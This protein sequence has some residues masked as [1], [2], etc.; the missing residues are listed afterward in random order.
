MRTLAHFT[1]AAALIGFGLAGLGTGCGGST[2]IRSSAAYAICDGPGQCVA[3][4]PGCC[5]GCGAPTLAE[6]TGVNSDKQDA[7][8]AATC[9]DPHPVCPACPTAPEPNLVAYCANGSCQAHDVRVDDVSACTKDD[10]CMLRAASCCEPCGPSSFELIALAKTH[11]SDY[12]AKVCRPDAACSKCLPVYPAGLTASCA[13]DGHCRVT[14]KGNVCPESQPSDGAPCTTAVTCEY[15]EDIRPGCRT[16]ATCSNA[17]WQV[18]VSGCPPLPQA[19][20]N[21][22]PSTESSDPCSPEGLACD[23]GGDTTCVCS[24]CLGGPCSPNPRWVCSGPPTTEGCGARPARLGSPCDTEGLV[25]I[26]GSLCT[27]PVAAGRR[28]KDGAWTDEPLACPV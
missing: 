7:F 13:S 1:S 18:A 23:M 15:G 21:G 24:G 3:L 10:D 19:G 4:V 27:P 2:D 22:C 6:V 8:R 5:G 16:H 25:C 9:G 28:C 20:E 12:R 11:A 17:T 14:E 26:Y